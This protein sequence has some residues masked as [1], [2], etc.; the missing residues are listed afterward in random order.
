VCA[1]R[2]ND[3]AFASLP[4]DSV[5]PGTLEDAID[6]VVPAF[7]VSPRSEAEVLRI[8]EI[9]QRERMT[10]AVSGSGSAIALGNPPRTCDLRISTLRMNSIV[11]HSPHDLTVTVES[12]VS[13]VALNAKLALEG[14]RVPVDLPNGAAATV[15]GIVASNRTGGFARGFGSPRDLALGLD[16]I[17]GRGR[18]L[19]CGGRVVKNVAGYD[20]TRL[21]VGSWGTL[22]IITQV[23]LRTAP[24]PI[25]ACT[26]A[27]ALPGWAIVERMRT[28]KEISELP[29][30]ALDFEFAQGSWRLLARI[31][32]DPCEVA[33][34]RARLI[35]LCEGSIAKTNPD[36]TSPIHA[37]SH[38]TFV[39]SLGFQ[40]AL[41]VGIAAKLADDLLT[42]DSSLRIAG[43]LQ[44]G[45][46]R[47][48]SQANTG[49]DGMTL[50]ARL[51]DVA[52]RH[53]ARIALE[54]V[55]PEVKTTFDVWGPP[56]EA[57]HLTAGIKRTFDPDARLAPGRFIGRL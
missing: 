48:F 2:V 15:G 19:R 25:E 39:A 16:A 14:Q 38:E 45:L 46:L 52:R 21:F 3:Q 49:S 22:G 26:L 23:T 28:A 29:L 36:W 31:E 24:L 51:E 1:A 11:E 47:V 20:L 6:G 43:R 35:D 57:V 33:Y 9:A 32:G 44:D 17:D 4:R 7:V 27:L 42:A 56:T 12:G 41:A 40:P 54:R 55:P 53:A 5:R 13:L 37:S 34:Q 30:A 18:L 8:V 10:L 50:A